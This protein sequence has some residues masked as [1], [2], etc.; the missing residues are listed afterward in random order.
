MSAFTRP[1]AIAAPLC[2]AALLLV[3]LLCGLFFS[4]LQSILYAPAIIAL[5]AFALLA[6]LPGCWGS[7]RVPSSPFALAVLAFWFY[8]TLSLS[9]STV[10]FSSLVTYLVACV[11]PLSFF[12]LLLA[13]DRLLWLR[14]CAVAVL[15]AGMMLAGWAVIQGLFLQ[16]VYYRAHHPLQ[17][18]NNL[19]ELLALGFFAILPLYLLPP[20]RDKTRRS[21]LNNFIGLAGAGL[22]F[23]GMLATESR[24]ALFATLLALPLLLFLMRAEGRR[25]VILLAVLAGLS[26]VMHIARDGRLLHRV[27][28]ITTA[29]SGEDTFKQRRA[30]WTAALAIARDHGPKGTGLGTFYLYY[31]S[32]RQPLADDSAGSWVHNDPLQ[33]AAE[34]GWPAPALFY[35]ILILAVARTARALPHAPPRS[36]QRAAIAAPFCALLTLGVA[37]HTDFP[38]YIM[39]VTL[40]AGLLLAVWYDATARALAL[41]P[42]AARQMT[43]RTVRF[44]GW[45]QSFAGIMTIAVAAM[46]ALMAASSAAGTHYVIAAQ[47]ELRQ[48]HYGQFMNFLNKADQYGPASFIDPAVHNAGLF[49]DTLIPPAGLLS[50]HEQAAI[51]EQA[52]ALLAHAERFN[53]AWAEINYKRGRLYEVTGAY[54]LTPDGADKAAAEYRIAIGKNPLH[55]RARETLAQLLSAAGDPAAAFDILAAGLEYPLPAAIDETYLPLMRALQG[56]PAVQNR[57]RK[58]TP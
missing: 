52:L 50:P 1:G 44:H 3:S 5:L 7:L 58:D 48:G 37:A 11:L 30:L 25:I 40:C 31:P 6:I 35:L 9:W 53:P 57:Y 32:Y 55:Y 33:F 8:V 20:P 46:L 42:A 18:P 45:Q 21:G 23:A 10:P 56:Q 49:I 24:T 27:T 41:A 54:G 17:N 43:D 38:F 26:G 29:G 19:G 34:M 12:A 47:K 2:G 28:N 14:C 16:E 36:R 39:P 22:F 51:K 15:G 13:Q 4:G